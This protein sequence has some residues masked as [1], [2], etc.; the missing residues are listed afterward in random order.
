MTATKRTGDRTP[1]AK[2]RIR[3]HPFN[4]SRKSAFGPSNQTK[5][6]IPNRIAIPP[7]TGNP[8]TKTVVKRRH[9]TEEHVHIFDSIRYPSDDEAPQTPT[10]SAAIPP[11][12]GNPVPAT[13]TVVKRQHITE[14]NNHILDAIPYSGDDEAPQTPTVS[15][16]PPNLTGSL[17][18]ACLPQNYPTQATIDHQVTSLDPLRLNRILRMYEGCLRKYPGLHL[19]YDVG[20]FLYLDMRTTRLYWV[21]TPAASKRFR[22]CRPTLRELVYILDL[23]KYPC[24][25][26]TYS[27][28][29]MRW[30]L[31]IVSIA[32]QCNDRSMPKLEPIG[33]HG[34]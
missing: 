28:S 27:P 21:H 3:Q 29:I 20:S 8:V 25:P 24:P 17:I 1:G 9:I 11:L 10:L 23:L 32:F 5:K 34:V 6:S 7:L 14:E 18:P 2:Y 26:N 30:A 31:S 22:K 4:G 16:A 15:T 13:K 12:T 33:A 19:C